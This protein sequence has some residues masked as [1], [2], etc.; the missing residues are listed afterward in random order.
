MDRLLNR[1]WN[2]PVRYPDPAMETGPAVCRV[3]SWER[4][5]E[6]LWVGGRWNEGPVWFGDSNALLWSDIPNNRLCGGRQILA[7]WQNAS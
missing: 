3:Y 2:Q 1:D 6:R 4:C 7:W 5:A